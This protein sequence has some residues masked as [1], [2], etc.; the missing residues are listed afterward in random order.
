MTAPSDALVL[1]GRG[2][3]DAEMTVVL[4]GMPLDQLDA[5]IRNLENDHSLMMAIRLGKRKY[6]L[7]DYRDQNRRI[8][9]IEERY[10]EDDILQSECGNEIRSKYFGMEWEMSPSNAALRHRP[11]GLEPTGVWTAPVPA[12]Q[13]RQTVQARTGRLK[14]PLNHR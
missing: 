9:D 2:F 5:T 4:N 7:P 10:N 14:P 1:P 13:G 8:V 3:R 11:Q 12:G 6:P